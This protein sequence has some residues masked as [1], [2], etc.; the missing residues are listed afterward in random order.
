MIARLQI[1]GQVASSCVDIL[2]RHD[3]TALENGVMMG[4]YEMPRFEMPHQGETPPALITEIANLGSA[5]EMYAANENR[6]RRLAEDRTRN[7]APRGSSTF[8]EGLRTVLSVWSDEVAKL[9]V[10]ILRRI[11]IIYPDL[12]EDAG[13]A[14]GNVSWPT[15]GDE[16]TANS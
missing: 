8:R 6:V 16:Q 14:L 9:S 5:V 12:A 10:Q 11:A 2:G 1:F 7:G 4:L 15:R 3:D 13:D